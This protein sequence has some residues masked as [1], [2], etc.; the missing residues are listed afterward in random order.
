[1]HFSDGV[2]VRGQESDYSVGV[3]VAYSEGCE[4]AEHRLL[5][6]RQIFF[7]FEKSL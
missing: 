6:K 5:M 4:A 7:F 3:E 1:M 2:F